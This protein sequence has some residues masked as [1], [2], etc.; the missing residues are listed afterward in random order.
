MECYA[1]DPQEI[2]DGLIAIKGHRF[3]KKE[4]YPQ[5]LCHMYDDDGNQSEDWEFI[6]DI[7]SDFKNTTSLYCYQNN[8]HLESWYEG[9]PVGR[10]KCLVCVLGVNTEHG[11]IVN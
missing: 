2:E 5:L 10:G 8:L 11:I 3:D 4:G 1:D 9:D 7:Y 6:F